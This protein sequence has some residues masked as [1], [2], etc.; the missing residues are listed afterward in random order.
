M[1]SLT[2]TPYW[3]AI[4]PLT[5]ANLYSVDTRTKDKSGLATSSSAGMSWSN[6]IPDES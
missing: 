5:S 3:S 1:N 4:S 2:A 6:N